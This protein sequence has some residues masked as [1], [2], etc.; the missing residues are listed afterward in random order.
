MFAESAGPATGGDPLDDRAFITIRHENGSISSISYQAAGDN[1]G[2][3]ERLEVFGGGRT[4]IVDEWD[5][6]ELWS[7]N[8]RST[9]RGGRNKGHE[10]E[11]DAFL[12]ACRQGGAW[13]ISWSDI[14]GT[15]WASLMAMRSLR[16]GR[17]IGIMETSESAI[18]ST[19]VGL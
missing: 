18:D 7:A 9:A 10:A 5:R 12:A 4:A 16:E 15:T 8:R 14:Y 11:I 19:V 13:P 6:I 2:P 3:I 17:P 1:A